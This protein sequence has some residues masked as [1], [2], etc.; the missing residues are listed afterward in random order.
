MIVTSNLPTSSIKRFQL[1]YLTSQLIKVS[2]MV[3][4]SCYLVFSIISRVL[5]Y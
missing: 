2:L 5:R 4:P 1:K 3:F